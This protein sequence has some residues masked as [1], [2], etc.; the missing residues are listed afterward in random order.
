MSCHLQGRRLLDV[1]GLTQ[2]GK[3][4]LQS[5]LDERT[6]TCRSSTLGRS[7]PSSPEQCS[8]YKA[9][10]HAKCTDVQRKFASAKGKIQD[11]VSSTSCD[12]ANPTKYRSHLFLAFGLAVDVGN[13][14]GAIAGKKRG[15]SL[16]KDLYMDVLRQIDTV[17]S[18][19]CEDMFPSTYR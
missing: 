6:Q 5:V 10:L 9:C 2:D 15:C 1:P 7:F 11:Y 17:L 13:C 4:N 18:K 12:I 19:S 14:L 8:A 3:Y 16:A